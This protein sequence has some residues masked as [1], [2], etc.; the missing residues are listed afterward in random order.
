MQTR[1]APPGARAAPPAAPHPPSQTRRLGAPSARLNDD[2]AVEKR[3]EQKRQRLAVVFWSLHN[4]RIVE[5]QYEYVH[6]YVH[7]YVVEVVSGVLRAVMVGARRKHAQR[8]LWHV[9]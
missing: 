7:V 5:K 9:V 6:V 4:H 3:E 2:R 8:L 1:G